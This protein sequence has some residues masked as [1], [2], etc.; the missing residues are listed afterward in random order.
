MEKERG[1]G[2]PSR[3]PPL[4]RAK[5]GVRDDNVTETGGAA[6]PSLSPLFPFLLFALPLSP[7]LSLRLSEKKRLTS[8]ARPRTPFLFLAL[9]DAF[10]GFGTR[11]VGSAL[12][13]ISWLARP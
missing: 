2:N 9:S 3:R 4:D 5:R 11:W 1:S 13:G 8:P 7:T 6:A 12:G 10:L